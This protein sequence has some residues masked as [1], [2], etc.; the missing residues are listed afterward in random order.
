MTLTIDIMK[1]NTVLS[2]D[3]RPI[4]GIY[5]PAEGHA[6]WTVGHAG[7]TRI[8][9]YDENGSM[10]HVPWL[11]VFVGDQISTRVPAEQVSVHYDV[12]EDCK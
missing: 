12:P 10:A 3:E 1:G 4:K 8:V 6:G 9:A 7:C 11:A 2:S 5:F